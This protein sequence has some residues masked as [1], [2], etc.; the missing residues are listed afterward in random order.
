M[1][2]CRRLYGRAATFWVAPRQPGKATPVTQSDIVR[3]VIIV[4]RHRRL[5]VGDRL[6]SIRELAERWGVNPSIVRSGYLQAAT[7]GIIRMHPRAGAFVAEFDYARVAENFS[8]LFEMAL[9]QTAPPLVDLYELRSVIERETF[10]RVA[11]RASPADLFK[12]REHLDVMHR[13]DERRD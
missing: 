5:A 13:T 6:P 11:R 3:K 4:I 1:P 10:G 12:L 8:M 7:L 2:S 9:D